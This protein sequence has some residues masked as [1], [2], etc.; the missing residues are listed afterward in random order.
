M[1]PCT[2]GYMQSRYKPDELFGKAKCKEDLLEEF[3]LADANPKLPVIWHRLAL[4][5]TKG[6]DL[7]LQV[8][9]RLAREEMILVVLGRAKNCMRKCLRRDGQGVSRQ[10]CVEDYLRQQDCAQ[11]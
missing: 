3:G 10:D 4:C 5:W 9:D 1:E 6:F 11:D 7:F 8:M 2:D